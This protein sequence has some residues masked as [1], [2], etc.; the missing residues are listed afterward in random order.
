MRYASL[1]FIAG[2]DQ[3]DNELIVLETIHRYVELLDRYFGNVCE[4]D[5]IYSYD[6]CCYVLDELLVGGEVVETSKKVALRAVAQ[7]D[8]LA[9]AQEGEEEQPVSQ[10]TRYSN[11]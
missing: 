2:V 9:D 7:M 4:L 6:R 10:Q 3:D 11:Y 1:Y 8:M 5:I